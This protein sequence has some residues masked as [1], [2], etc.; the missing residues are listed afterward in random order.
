MTSPPATSSTCPAASVL[1]AE[2]ADALRH[3]ADLLTRAGLPGLSLTFNDDRL[4]IQVGVELGTEPA[5]AAMVAHLASL[6]GTTSRRW[7]GPG[8]LADWI[9]ADGTRA[10]H[11]IH[12]FT[13]IGDSRP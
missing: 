11:A 7:G 3:A 8:P 5:R 13:A 6:L 12:I 1:L 10:G 2:Q 4:S 9:I